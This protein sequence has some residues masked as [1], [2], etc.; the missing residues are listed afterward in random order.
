MRKEH[1]EIHFLPSYFPFLL[2]TRADTHRMQLDLLPSG[3]LGQHGHVGDHEALK[4][5]SLLLPAIIH[6]VVVGQGCSKEDLAAQERALEVFC[7]E[8]LVHVPVELRVSHGQ[9]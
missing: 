7:G 9:L 3:L 6:R 2:Q 8:A 4:L 5:S 1:L